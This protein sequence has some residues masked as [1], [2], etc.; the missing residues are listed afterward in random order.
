M[1]LDNW[2][3]RKLYS[4]KM[5]QAKLF[6]ERAADAQMDGDIEAGAELRVRYHQMREEANDALDH[7]W[8]FI[9]AYVIYAMLAVLAFAAAMYFVDTVRQ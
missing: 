1:K 8:T 9:A 2:I 3:G 5:K 6:A 7:P 4:I